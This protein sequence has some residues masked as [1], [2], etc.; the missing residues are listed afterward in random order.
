MEALDWFGG[1]LR[2]PRSPAG[3]T[4]TT[5]IFQTAAAKDPV[6]TMNWLDQHADTIGKYHGDI[7]YPIAA[8]WLMTKSPEQFDAWMAN[9]S[10]NPSHDRIVETV[11]TS[12]IQRGNL[13]RAAQLAGT[14]QD[15][16]IAAKVNSAMQKQANRQPAIPR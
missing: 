15:P 12:L 11:A 2:Y 8:Q 5:M 1:Y 6:A 14:I 7:A 4:A 13:E 9:N 16:A 10:N 3:P